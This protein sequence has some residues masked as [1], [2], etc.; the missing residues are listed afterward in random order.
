MRLKFL[1]VR[2]VL[3]LPLGYLLAHFFLP[4]LRLP[5]FLS[6]AALLVFFAYVFEYLHRGGKS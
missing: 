4:N 6:L 2:V 1:L 5:G 3:A